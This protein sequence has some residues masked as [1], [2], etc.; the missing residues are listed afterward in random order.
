MHK[1]NYPYARPIP[2]PDSVAPTPY[3]IL[4]DQ[5]ATM[6]QILNLRNILSKY[7]ALGSLEEVFSNRTGLVVFFKAFITSAQAGAIATVPG[8]NNDG[9]FIL[10]SNAPDDLTAISQ[11]RGVSLDELPG[12][13]YAAEAGEGVTIYVIDWGAN[14]Q[15]PE[16]IGMTGSK[17]FIY[18]PGAENTETDEVNHGT[19]MASRA[20]SPT[21]GT[22]KAANIVMV[23]LPNKPMVS[24][25]FAALQIVSD[26]VNRKDIKGKAVISMSINHLRLHLD[27]KLSSP[28]LDISDRISTVEKAYKRRVVDIMAEDIVI[29]ASS[30]NQGVG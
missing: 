22:A 3:I 20:A 7:A 8:L 12:F 29:V 18:V 13:G 16:W 5:S 9:N 15:H 4:T 23:K 21:Y 24:D 11:P 14:S 26:D 17:S 6:E 30:G 28:D 27:D 2:L 1:R 25:Y 10:Q 19:C